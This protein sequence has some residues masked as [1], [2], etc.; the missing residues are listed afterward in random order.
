METADIQAGAG[1]ERRGRVGA[2]APDWIGPILRDQSSIAEDLTAAHGMR[3][4]LDRHRLASDGR[5]SF[6]CGACEQQLGDAHQ[7]DKE[8]GCPHQVLLYRVH[9]SFRWFACGIDEHVQES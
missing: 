6:R 3:P 4:V 2:G 1:S 8:F 9:I 5:G 7:S